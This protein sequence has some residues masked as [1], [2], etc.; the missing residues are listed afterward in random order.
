[1]SENDTMKEHESVDRLIGQLTD[2]LVPVRRLRAPWLRASLWIGLLLAIAGYFSMTTDVAAMLHRLGAAADMWLS[3][4]GSASTAILAA[5][6]VFQLSLPDRSPRWALLPLPGALLWIGAS[7]FGCLRVLIEPA[8]GHISVADP[9]DCFI[10]IISM[11]IPLSII[12]IWM[13][14]RAYTLRPNLTAIV[15]GLAVASAAATLLNF[16]H[17][18]N[19]TISD[20]AVHALAIAI[21]VSANRLL[22]GNL[23]NPSK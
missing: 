14:R 23:L 11:S 15:G 8:S 3:V 18:F 21:V 1:M 4:I 2:E 10:F 22:G 13:L 17:P 7:G 20:L 6:A 5:I 12:M 16:V 19:V 9:D